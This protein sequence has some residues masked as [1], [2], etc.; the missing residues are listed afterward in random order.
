MI[1]GKGGR[2]FVLGLLGHSLWHADDFNGPYS[3]TARKLCQVDQASGHL[4]G[5]MGF[6]RGRGGS[7]GEKGM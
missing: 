4:E 3:V 2:V 6:L 7:K 1:Q 5:G